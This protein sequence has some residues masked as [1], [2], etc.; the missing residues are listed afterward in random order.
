M[1]N[2]VHCK[3]GLPYDIYIGRPSAWGNPYIIGV[4]GT[5]EEVID[6][7]EKYYLQNVWMQD[8]ISE[9]KGKVLGC[10]CFPLA[11]HGDV[12]FKYAEAV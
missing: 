6:K 7:F 3:A 5:R 9:L 11:C 2:I 10:W 8:H 12:L 4:D 1:K